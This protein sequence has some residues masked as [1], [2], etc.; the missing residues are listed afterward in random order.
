M[1]GKI[2]FCFLT[3]ASVLFRLNFWGEKVQTCFLDLQNLH[4]NGKSL[5]CTL[6]EEKKKHKFL[7]LHLTFVNLHVLIRMIFSETKFIKGFSHWY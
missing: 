3:M 5:Q 1:L 4:S 2:E 7:S 6:E